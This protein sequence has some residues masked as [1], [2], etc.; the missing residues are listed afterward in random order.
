M[1]SSFTVADV[2][3]G[4]TVPSSTAPGR[5]RPDAFH[6]LLEGVGGIVI[7]APLHATMVSDG[8]PAPID[9]EQRQLAGRDAAKKCRRL[10]RE[11]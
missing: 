5:R 10:E 4:K 3:R 11:P 9:Q 8:K 6:E 2:Y 1:R 7:T